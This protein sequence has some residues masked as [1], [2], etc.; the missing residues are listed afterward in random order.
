[1]VLILPAHHTTGRNLSLLFE[2]EIIIYVQY[3]HSTSRMMRLLTE[4]GTP[5][6]ATE[7][8]R[9]KNMFDMCE[10]RIS[11]MKIWAFCAMVNMR[12]RLRYHRFSF[13][14][15]SYRYLKYDVNRKIINSS[16]SSKNSNG[17]NNDS[18]YYI[19]M[20]P[21]HCGWLLLTATLLHRIRLYICIVLFC[22]LLF[23]V[24]VCSYLFC[25]EK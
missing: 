4:G 2:C 14:F 19:D 22:F 3:L 23:S 12:L 21:F 17:M 6:V 20:L 8:T 1:M 13:E 24:S 18:G 7:R 10:V 11:W 16:I 9:K 25:A 15:H 5:F